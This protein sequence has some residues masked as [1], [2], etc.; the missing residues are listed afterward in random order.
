MEIKFLN[1]VPVV[2]KKYKYVF[3]ILLIGLVLMMLPAN[4]TKKPDI[5]QQQENAVVQTPLEDRLANILCQ[6]E[7]A[8]QVEVVLTISAG[9]ETLFQENEDSTR[10]DNDTSVRKDTVLISDSDHNETGLVRQ[11]LP[12]VYQGAIIVCQGADNLSVRLE[13]VDAV[14]KLTGLGANCISVLKMK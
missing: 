7:G 5:L 13:I 2:C 6:V 3:L 14:S 8:G 4:K 1:K 12:A 11:V 10:G 9:E